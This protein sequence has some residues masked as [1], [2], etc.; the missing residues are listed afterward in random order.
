MT[1]K[2]G[3]IT[4][5]AA[6]GSAVSCASKPSNRRTCVPGSSTID[7]SRVWTT[8]R[9]A[10]WRKSIKRSGQ[11]Q[12][13]L[14]RRLPAGDT[15]LVEAIFGV[16]RLE[17]C[18]LAGVT[19]RAEVRDASFS[20]ADCA[21]LMHGENEWTASVSPLEN[22]VQWKAMPRCGGVCQPV[23]AGGGDRLSPRHGFARRTHGNC[24]LCG[25][26]AR[27][28]CGP[29]LHEF[30]GRSADRLADAYAGGMRAGRPSA[31]AAA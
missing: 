24:A 23:G 20:D 14:A 10:T 2:V 12:L 6:T 7:Q 31:R 3:E 29:V 28:P 27:A 8:Y 15:H 22:A 26:M 16:R 25:G 21:A 30:T 1:D 11:Q 18:R 9:S 5:K 13:G 17:A 4:P 19:W